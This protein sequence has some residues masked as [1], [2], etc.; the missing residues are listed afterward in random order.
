MNEA[1]STTIS[2]WLADATATLDAA[3]IA[4]ARLDC[5]VLLHDIL[6]QDKSWI[7]AHSEYTLQRSEKQI[8]NTLIAQRAQHV[9][10]AYLRGKVEFYGR[11]FV[12]TEQ[13]LTPRPESEALIELLSHYLAGHTAQTLIDIGTG[14]GC[15]GITAKLEFP[16]L[17]TY[18]FDIDDDCVAVAQQNAE[19]H[20]AKIHIQSSDL[21]SACDERLLGAQ[22]VL[23]AN[24]PYVPEAH[25]LNR[26]ATYEPRKALFSGTDGLDHYRRLFADISRAKNRGVGAVIT[27]SMPE[28]HRDLAAI[29]AASGYNQTDESG[30]AQ[31]F[32]RVT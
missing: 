20:N 5:L 22:T 29:A 30:Y 26:A 31:L 23:L 8:L 24:L 25:P 15:L 11:E 32:V 21:L 14:S 2:R 16:S 1:S 17:D 19:K 13:V 4:T 7:I 10:L 9:P 28:Q 6:E 18:A 12:I 3:G 27:E